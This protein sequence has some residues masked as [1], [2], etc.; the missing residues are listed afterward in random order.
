MNDNLVSVNQYDPEKDEFISIITE[1]GTGKRVRLSDFEV[2]TRTRRGLQVI[3]EVKTNPYKILKTFITD[4]RNYIGLK[5]SDINK[6]KL[7]ELPISDRHS[8]G[9]QITK[10]NITDAYLDAVLVR[11]NKEQINLISEEEVSVKEEVEEVKPK[12]ERISLKEID[13]RLMT[14]D[15]FLK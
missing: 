5:N 10:H 14:I 2:S 11:N 6:Y 12:K 9:S 15:D 13:D 8:T 1:K 4:S 3:R 7:T